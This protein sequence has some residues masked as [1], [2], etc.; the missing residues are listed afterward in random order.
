VRPGAAFVYFAIL[1]L[2]VL[3]DLVAQGSSRVFGLAWSELFTLLLPALIAAEGSNLR[4]LHYLG[5][6]RARALPILLG[7]LLGAAGFLAAN[8]VMIAWVAVL[9]ARVLAAFPDVARIFEGSPLVQVVVVFVAAALA[10]L[11]E[12]VAF[13]GYLQRTLARSLGPA[14]AIG[15]TAVLFGVRHLDLVRFPALVL[16]GAV[17]GWAAWRSG[18]I[19]PA[20]AAH[21]TNNALATALAIG[22][23][24]GG[25]AARPALADA[26]APLA[27]GGVA[28]AILAAGLRLVTPAPP[29]P[30]EAIA[31]RDP[32]DPSTRFRL[33]RVPRVLTRAAAAGL[34]ALSLLALLAPLWEKMAGP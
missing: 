16:L 4:A 8:G 23:G 3:P 9:P 24:G 1:F 18:S 14:A 6:D 27:A 7:A 25:D 26:L 19:W 21:A 22:G 30:E 15:L 20:V 12:E 29:P 13:R 28:L 11:C 31:L 2:L 34:A 17:F 32:A 33:D 5:L 10:P